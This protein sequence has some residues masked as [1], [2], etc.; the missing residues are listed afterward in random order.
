LSKGDCVLESR[1]PIEGKI[2]DVLRKAKGDA[3]NGFVVD[4]DIP[5]SE[6][7]K[8]ATLINIH[9]DGFTHGYEIKNIK[10]IRGQTVIEL[11]DEPGYEIEDGKTRLLFFP[12]RESKG[13]NRF[14]ITNYTTN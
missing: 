7:L 1:G 11:T 10:K 9:P 3:V 14:R 4:V 5:P 8:G 2:L 6:Q 13:E 12:Q